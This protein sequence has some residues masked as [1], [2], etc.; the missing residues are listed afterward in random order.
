MGLI[1]VPYTVNGYIF[2]QGLRPATI[3]ERKINITHMLNHIHVSGNE[4]VI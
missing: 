2:A 4:S 3:D 1:L